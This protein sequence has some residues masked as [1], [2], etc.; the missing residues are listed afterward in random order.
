MKCYIIVVMQS[1]GLIE[2]LSTLCGIIPEYWDIFGNKHVASYETKAAVL[3]AMRVDVDSEEEILREISERQ[4]RPWKGLIEPVHVVSVNEQPLRIPL[5]IRIQ[6]GREADLMI[7]WAIRQEKGASGSSRGSRSQVKGSAIPVSEVRWIDG[8]RYIKVFLVDEKRRSIGYYSLT[9]E[10]S[11]PDMVAPEQSQTTKRRS[12]I[13]VAPDECYMP[14]HLLAGRAWGI[15]INLYSIRSKRNWGMGDFTDLLDIVHWGAGLKCD[16]I[17]INPLHAIPNSKPYGISPYSPLSRLYKNFIYLDIGKVPEISGSAEIRKH[18]ASR[19]FRKELNDAKRSEFIDYDKV[20][21]LKMDLLR[22]AF[23][24][25]YKRHYARNTGRG[26]DFKKY[27]AE[28]GPALD[29][30]ALFMSLWEYMKD[31]EGVYTWQ[32]WPEEYRSITGSSVKAFRKSHSKEIL[33]YQYLQWLTDCQLMEVAAEAEGLGMK[34]G[35]YNDLAVGS[36]GGGSDAWNYQDIIASDACLGAPPD[37]FNSNGQKWGF[38]PFIP[39]KLKESGYELFIETMRKNMKY[40]GAL[41]I[42]HALGLFRLFWI[43]GDMHAKDGAYVSCFAEDLIRIIALESVLHRT[44]IIA[45]DLGTIGENARETLQ[46]FRM[47]S[48]RLFY[49]ERNYPDPSFLEPGKYPETALCAVTTH[50]LPTLYGYWAGRDIEVKREL[51]IFSGGDQLQQQVCDRERDKRLIISALHA[52][53]I[54]PASCPFDP[55]LLPGMT[56]ELCL[57]VYQYLTRTPCRMLL[58][59][60]DDIIGTLNQQ[61]LP[62]TVDAHPNWK[63]KT[64]P[65]LEQILKDKRFAD[66]AEMMKKS[67]PIGSEA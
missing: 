29:T 10:C 55:G 28:E 46:K 9:V 42:D 66:L 27:I 1:E 26:G 18:A 35:L 32:E 50:D 20:A 38:P 59:S 44:V 40:G 65:L 58:V 52:N 19:K 61:N 30:F 34:T 45:E 6:E 64:Q 54:L 56:P 14:D 49:F 8:E 63:Q 51:N 33:F 39:E 12:R 3:K 21:S 67:L 57:A 4:A 43:P 53:G 47:L 25:F 17:G 23:D 24:V 2:E 11:H 31:K 60:L 37:D 5:Y 41:R 36:V 62:G 22:Q 15:A 16:C 7:S 48:Y 13:I